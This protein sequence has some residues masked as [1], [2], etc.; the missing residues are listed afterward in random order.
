MIGFFKNI[1]SW[2]IWKIKN[3]FFLNQWQLL[4]TLKDDINFDF[5]NFIKI[6]PPKDRFWADPFIVKHKKK[7]FI[8]FE[9]LIYKEN[10]GSICCLNIDDDGNISKIEQLN[11][12][13]VINF[14]ICGVYIKC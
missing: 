1:I 5:R 3:Q 13:S 14:L 10:K 9:E 6:I 8:F 4:Y 2:T 12:I 11:Y 7:F